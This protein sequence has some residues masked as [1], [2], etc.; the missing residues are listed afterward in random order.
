MDKRAYRA[1][2]SRVRLERTA[3]QLARLYIDGYEC[4]LLG[5]DASVWICLEGTREM[6][7][8]F[9]MENAAGFAERPPMQVSR[10]L[11]AVARMPTPNSL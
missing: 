6:K 2:L 11:A 4:G 1:A 9:V 3:D 10:V 7:C 8:M 5:Q